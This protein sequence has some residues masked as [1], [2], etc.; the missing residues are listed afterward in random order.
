MLIAA[1]APF[2]IDKININSLCILLLGANTLVLFFTNRAIKSNANQIL[3]VLFAAFFVAHAIGFLY[4]ENKHEAGLILERKLS[5]AV[6][7]IVFFYGPKMEL[8]HAKQIVLAFAASCFLMCIV[9]LGIALYKYGQ[10]HDVEV[11]FYHTLS[12]NVGMHA[13]YLALYLCF[14]ISSLLYFINTEEKGL[15]F[16]QK[17]AV[18]FA[19][20]LMIITVVL[21]SARL[22]LMLMLIVF[23]GYVIMRMKLYKS[24]IKL[25][26]AIVLL[27]LLLGGLI[28]LS[29]K[30]RERFKEAINY[31]G[32]YA[33]N[34]KWGEKQMRFLIWNSASD[35]IKKKSLFGYG[36]GDVQEVLQETYVKNEY[37]SL[38]Y[39]KNTRFNAHN[40]FLETT[41]AL[42]LMGL[43]IFVI[44]IVYALKVAIKSKN[45]LYITFLFLFL[46]SCFT[47]SMLERQN[48]IVFF[49]FFNS[50]LIIYSIKKDNQ[51]LK[52]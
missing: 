6:F 25:I 19:F 43:C 17:S 12:N 39:W 21:L 52:N 2:N 31:K 29:P 36:T 13:S 3:F 35:L 46:A 9:S 44:S 15:S 7:P 49:S 34:K 32:E 27:T 5:L 16:I 22:Q 42:G 26:G 1:T 20:V 10:T 23:I 51:A 33:L 41:L 47:E 40:Q 37:V 4:S 30:N 14:S 38:T 45:L 8:K 50:F 24:P 18:G 11:F 48:G 28:L